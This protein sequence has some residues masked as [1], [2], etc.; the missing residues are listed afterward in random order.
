VTRSV[1]DNFTSFLRTHRVA[2]L[3]VVVVDGAVV[4]VDAV[5]VGVVSVVVLVSV[6]IEY[7]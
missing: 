7:H 6:L 1:V 3:V 2:V 4:E 5:A